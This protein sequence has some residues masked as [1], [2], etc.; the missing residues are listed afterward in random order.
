M[1][2][3]CLSS[4]SVVRIFPSA[5]PNCLSHY[6]RETTNTEDK[7]TLPHFNKLINQ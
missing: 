5:R 6:S 4:Q 7:F 3:K 1:T 2:G